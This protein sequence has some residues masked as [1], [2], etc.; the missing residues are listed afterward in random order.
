MD[1]SKLT[2]LRLVEVPEPCHENWDAM[3]G[4]EAKRLCDSCGCH[5][6]NLEEFDADQAEALLNQ[7]NK[8]CIRMQLDAQR[9]VKVRNGWIPQ[10]I[11]ASVLASAAAL[12]PGQQAQDPV[13]LQGKPAPP[14][15]QPK[16]T[17]GKL[18]MPNVVKGQPTRPTPTVKNVKKPV[19][20]KC[21]KNAT[22]K[23]KPK[24]T[25]KAKSKPNP[26][27]KGK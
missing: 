2:R 12:S 16:H 24:V 7:P 18:V 10:L 3:S 20:I 23:P 8:V 13:P 6:H 17:V 14:V 19:D 27:K 21:V 15:E 11:A 4:D 22:A 25:P 9:G 26:K 1:L 5:V